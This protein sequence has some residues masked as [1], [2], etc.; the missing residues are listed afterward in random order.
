M[1]PECSVRS[2]APVNKAAVRNRENSVVKETFKCIT[3]GF[4][5]FSGVAKQPFGGGGELKFQV[6]ERL[7]KGLMAVWSPTGAAAARAR[8]RPQ[9]VWGES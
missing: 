8:N 7:S 2:A 5:R 4:R 6:V 1:F 3:D 9:T